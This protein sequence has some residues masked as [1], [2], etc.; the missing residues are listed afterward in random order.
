MHAHWKT[1]IWTR[2][3][4][5]AIKV[6]PESES[7]A[8]AAVGAWETVLAWQLCLPHSEAC[9]AVSPKHQYKNT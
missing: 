5:C 1:T 6:R 8:L 3:V 2:L 9:A 4:F 7:P